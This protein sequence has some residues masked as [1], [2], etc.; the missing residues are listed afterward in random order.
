MTEKQKYYKFL[1]GNLESS[2]NPNFYYPTPVF[3]NGKWIP[4][5]WIE[6]SKTAA[7]GLYLMKVLKPLYQRYTGNCYEAEGDELL[8]EDGERAK[9]V[10]VRL[11]RPVSFTEIFHSSADLSSANLC[12]MN[13]RHVNLCDTNLRHANLCDTNLRGANLRYVDLYHA[14]LCYADLSYANLCY[15]DL[16]YANLCHANL[17]H[18][19]LCYTDLSYADLRYADLNHANLNH[20]NLRY[21]DLYHANLRYADFFEHAYING[22]TNLKSAILTN[23][24]RDIIREKPCNYKSAKKHIEC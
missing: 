13:L 18:A 24:I 16:S 10:R 23:E 21:A 14:N 7:R 8:S 11:V 1:T 17:Y 12:D 5:K 4:T 2:D 9:F 22:K 6:S 19:N 20:A 15:T 3:K